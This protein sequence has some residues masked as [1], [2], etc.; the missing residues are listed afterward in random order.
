MMDQNEIIDL[1]KLNEAFMGD[2]D[3]IKQILSAFQ[4]TVANF[5]N[6][7]KALDSANDNEQ[8]SRLVHGLK[9]SAANIRAERVA[10]QAAYMQQLID[11]KKN[12][13][14][15]VDE[16]LVSLSQLQNQINAIKATS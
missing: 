13:A 3:I 4:D 6:D 9:G 16:L 14:A 8:L 10:K 5:E 15:H 1:A 7:F 11:Q 2:A 12:Y